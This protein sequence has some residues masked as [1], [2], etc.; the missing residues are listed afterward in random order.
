[1]R[2]LVYISAAK[3]KCDPSELAEILE[4]ARRNNARL[5]VSGILLYDNGSFLQVLEGDEAVV[6]ELYEKIARDPRHDRVTVL[7]EHDTDARSFGDWTMG[8]VSL[9]PAILKQLPKRHSLSSNGSLQDVSAETVRAFL[10]AFRRGRWRAY[11][12]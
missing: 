2:E 3:R 5:G 8:Y 1:M 12:G 6:R 11:I 4:V 7:S 10:D 9:N